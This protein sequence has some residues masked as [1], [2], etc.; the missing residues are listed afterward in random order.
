MSVV[1]PAFN[2]A[3]GIAA[4]HDRL[5]AVMH[6]LGERWEVIYVNDGSR[7]ATL[8]DA[9]SA[10]RARPRGSR[11]S[12]CRA[13]SARRSPSPPASI[14]RSGEAVIVIDADLQDPPEVIPELVAAW[15][16]GVRRR[17]RAAPAARRAKPG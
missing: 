10:A 8:G 5:A 2:E 12:T 4:F 14:M 9:A 3:E 13:I 16:D 6:T 7:D 17:L 15:R 11:W 1:V